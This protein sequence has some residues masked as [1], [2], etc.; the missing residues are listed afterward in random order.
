MFTIFRRD[1]DEYLKRLARTESFGARTEE[2]SNLT[3]TL[4][5]ANHAERRV[6]IREALE[7]M[8]DLTRWICLRRFIEDESPRDIARPLGLTANA[9]SVRLSRGLARVRNLFCGR[10]TYTAFGS[11]DENLVG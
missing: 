11:E 9:V 10:P 4:C 3:S 8:D 2:Y 7:S 1:A 5:T 6:L